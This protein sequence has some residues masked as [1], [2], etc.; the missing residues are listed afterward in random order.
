MIAK[1]QYLHK[2][3]IHLKDFG[4]EI[5]CLNKQSQVKD[6]L[7]LGDLYIFNV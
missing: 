6:F 2:F 3:R 7:E 1:I 4:F 5:R